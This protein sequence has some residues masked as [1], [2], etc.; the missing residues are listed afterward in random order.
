MFDQRDSDIIMKLPNLKYLTVDAFQTTNPTISS[1]SVPVQ[2]LRVTEP[3]DGPDPSD[4]VDLNVSFRSLTHLTIQSLGL[5]KPINC[6]SLISIKFRM[7][8]LWTFSDTVFRRNSAA[9]QSDPYSLAYAPPSPLTEQ[10]EHNIGAKYLKDVSG[11]DRLEIELHHTH[12]SKADHAFV[13]D[14][15]P[16]SSSLS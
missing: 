6:P 4:F 13:S 12:D 10:T 2:H 9:G 8:L 5:T 11:L 1:R 15:D 7:D 3:L 16:V 14:Y